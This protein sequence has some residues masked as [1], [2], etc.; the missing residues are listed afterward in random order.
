MNDGLLKWLTIIGGVI[1]LAGTLLGAGIS[2]GN[3]M[4]ADEEQNQRLERQGTLIDDVNRRV[5]RLEWAHD[6]NHKNEA[7]LHEANQSKGQP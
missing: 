4:H 1:A 5:Y 3:H 6:E 7:P 2:Y